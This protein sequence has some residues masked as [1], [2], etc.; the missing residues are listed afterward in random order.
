VAFVNRRLELNTKGE[1]MND[2]LLD[3]A[4]F[5]PAIMGT[6]KR[7]SLGVGF[8]ESLRAI[9][10][11]WRNHQG[12][13][14]QA[15]SKEGEVITLPATLEA[16]EQ[17]EA[18]NVGPK[19]AADFITLAELEKLCQEKPGEYV[20][21]GLLAAADVHVAV[22][23]SGLGKTPW[24]YQLG[25]C[26]A[27]KRPFLGHDVKQGRVLY[28]DLENG[29]DQQL[30]LGHSICRHLEIGEMPPDF[31]VFND[32]GNPAP[33]LR[34]AIEENKPRLVIIDTLRAF[35]PDVE[36]ANDKMGKFLLDTRCLARASNSAI[37]LLHHIRKPG[38]AKPGDNG[39]PPLEGTPTL[40]W[41]REAAGA[42]ALINQTT[43][44][45]AFD[46]PGG[47]KAKDAALVMK[48][49]VKIK[50]ESA[51]VY[52]ERICDDYGDPVGYR[53]I[54]GVE[55]LGDE[56]QKA[57]FNRLPH[58]F[59]FKEAK[60]TY[61]KTDDPTRKWLVKCIAAGLMKQVGRGAYERLH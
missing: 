20:V 50:G 30:E 39:V 34:K 19:R 53:S 16:A 17:A 14:E 42:R 28:F 54:V 15:P 60:R 21:E 56:H 35:R 23:D 41:L 10:A 6:L 22:G 51:P 38:P 33:S 5:A 1:E 9:S 47:F 7:V 18:P 44:R 45:I 4:S 31:L 26:V 29:R 25:L 59:S 11:K 37:L 3:R 24:A 61:D 2:K 27:A 48:Y 12:S 52:L 40:E 43:T 36:E 58:Q 55:L 46:T 8:A 32:N 13:A 57:A 49:F